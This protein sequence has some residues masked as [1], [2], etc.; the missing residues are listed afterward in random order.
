MEPKSARNYRYF[1]RV[2]PHDTKT[3]HP[4]AIP[5]G[6]FDE[7]TVALVLAWTGLLLMAVATVSMLIVFHVF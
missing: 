3:V 1:T 6:S 5:Y 7:D 4:R 2:T